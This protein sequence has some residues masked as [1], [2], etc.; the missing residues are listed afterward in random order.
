MKVKYPSGLLF[1]GF[2]ITCTATAVNLLIFNLAHAFG[3]NFIIPI[4]EYSPVKEPMPVLLVVV[5]TII[6]SILAIIL[7]AFLTKFAPKSVMPSFLSVSLTALL[8]SF[9]GPF[10]LPETGFQTK[11]IL[12][13]MHIMTAIIIV[14]GLVG[15]YKIRSSRTIS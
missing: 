9:G 6:P 10:S 8:V 3:E 14:G 4:S 5:A 1:S 15:Y 12:A 11:L 13:A 2:L 7:F